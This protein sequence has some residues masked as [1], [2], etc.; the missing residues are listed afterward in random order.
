MIGALYLADTE[1]TMW[2]EWYRHLAELGVPPN[3]QMPRRVRQWD[4]E[5]A[6]ANLAADRRLRR[7]R[8][9]RPKPGRKTWPRYQAVG[10][11]LWREGWRGL[12]APSA[13]RPEGRVLCLF[14]EGRAR[15][16]G[17]RPVGRGRRIDEPP[18]PPT[19]MT[20]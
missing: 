12:I 18:A 19:G 8:L 3:E 4:V 9:G 13:A 2:A 5:V 14:R 1:E 6:V 11:R 10:E 17:V 7:V 15:I 16:E 20:T